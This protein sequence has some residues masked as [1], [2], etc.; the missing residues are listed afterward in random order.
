MRISIS[1]ALYFPVFCSADFKK[2]RIPKAWN[3]VR[4][5]SELRRGGDGTF[6]KKKEALCPGIYIIARDMNLG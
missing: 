2:M 4:N 6:A 5:R 3:T 1:L